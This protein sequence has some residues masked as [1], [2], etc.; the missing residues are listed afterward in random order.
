MRSFPMWRTV[1]GICLRNRMSGILQKA[2]QR[3]TCIEARELI[4]M[5]PPSLIDY[6]DDLL[7]KY[8]TSIFLENMMWDAMRHYTTIRA[9]PIYIF[10]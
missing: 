3:G 4:I 8:M 7:L 2:E 6:D 5:L 10:I 1:T 9:K